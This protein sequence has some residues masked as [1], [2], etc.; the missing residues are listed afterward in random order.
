MDHHLWFQLGSKS[1]R[2]GNLRD[3]RQ[4]KGGRRGTGSVAHRQRLLLPLLRLLRFKAMQASAMCSGQSCQGHVAV[5]LREAKRGT[6]LKLPGGGR[7]L[8]RVAKSVAGSMTEDRIA[9]QARQALF[10]TSPMPATV[11]SANP[12]HAVY[13]GAGFGAR[14]AIREG[15]GSRQAPLAAVAAAA[16]PAAAAAAAAPPGTPTPPVSVHCARCTGRSGRGRAPAAN[17]ELS[18]AQRVLLV[19]NEQ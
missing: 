12:D 15:E 1:K 14:W 6:T 16:A 10:G 13:E 9:S 11:E 3:G 17:D 4:R 7:Q 19:P 18:N 2:S 5:N 8:F